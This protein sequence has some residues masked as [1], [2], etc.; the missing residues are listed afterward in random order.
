MSLVIIC[1]VVFLLLS[2]KFFSIYIL[3]V[4][5]FGLVLRV[6]RRLIGYERLMICLGIVWVWEE[7][8]FGLFFIM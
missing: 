3:E 5:R 1:L 8:K 2:D 7:G 6:I 4:V